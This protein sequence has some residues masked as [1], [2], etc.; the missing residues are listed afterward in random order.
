[1]S[2]FAE[3]NIQRFD[4]RSIFIIIK[5]VNEA[6]KNSVCPLL[7]F[8]TAIMLGLPNISFKK[9][10]DQ[11][12]GVTLALFPRWKQTTQ[13]KQTFYSQIFLHSCQGENLFP[14]HLHNLQKKYMQQDNTI[15][16]ITCEICIIEKTLLN[17]KVG[18][19]AEWV[20]IMNT[21]MVH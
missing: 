17:F 18:D 1:M 16:A 8:E 6:N 4:R 14:A 12:H 3:R 21:K 15:L 13:P 10:Q 20:T 2:V 5:Y 19:S 7:R 9:L 11:F